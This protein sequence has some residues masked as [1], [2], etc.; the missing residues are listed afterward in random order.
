MK[1]SKRIV[2]TLISIVMLLLSLITVNSATYRVGDVNRDNSIDVSDVTDIQFYVARASV[3]IDTAFADFNG[4]G[5]INIDDC[6]QVQMYIA[7]VTNVY[8]GYIYTFDG[9]KATIVGYN[10]SDKDLNIPSY[11]YG[12]NHSFVSI[13]NN[14]FRGKEN[15]T[16]VTIPKSIESI[17]YYAFSDCTSLRKVAVKNTNCHIDSSSFTNCPISEFK[18]G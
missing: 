14:A 8:G 15:I 7:G 12:F 13:G 3:I 10:G 6:T 4:D 16:S 11:A 1:L 18:V 9:N 5:F 17:G 2:I